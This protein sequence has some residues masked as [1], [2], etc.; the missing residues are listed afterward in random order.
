MITN[1]QRIDRRILQQAVSLQAVGHHVILIAG[2]LDGKPSFEWIQGVRVERFIATPSTFTDKII[3]RVFYELVKVKNNLS[4]L[5]RRPKDTLLHDVSMSSDTPTSR[6]LRLFLLLLPR[7]KSL[8]FFER[9]LLERIKFYRPDIIHA[10]D[11]PQLRVCSVAGK[12]LSSPLIYDAHELY[13]EIGTLSKFSR[14]KLKRIERRYIKSC[15]AITTVNPYIATELA[16]RY[17]INTPKVILNTLDFIEPQKNE[18]VLRSFLNLP[19]ENEI[20]LY[21]G[22]MSPE[23]GLDLLIN[24]FALVK[25]SAHLVF[26]GYGDH[27]DLLQAQ[28]KIIGIDHRVH[29]VPPVSQDELLSWTRCANVGVIPYPAI[30]LNHKFCSPNKLFEFIQSEV[31]IVANDL[32]FLR[33]VVLGEEI[34]LVAPIESDR[35]FAD[36]I[37]S[38]LVSSSE[39]DSELSQ[40]L[41]SAKNKFSWSHQEVILYSVFD[42]LLI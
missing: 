14:L 1:D 12:Q 22:W 24:A 42:E 2:S 5:W 31:P 35:E 28:S 4:Q 15:S 19:T 10:H 13:T 26:M 7:H 27:Q 6:L 32:P 36:A 11:L 40:A 20:V 29:F 18:N 23:R 37:N 39:S 16:E 38:L 33:D 30:D 34:G 41:V 17:D 21:Q 8:S 3:S 9:S 25:N